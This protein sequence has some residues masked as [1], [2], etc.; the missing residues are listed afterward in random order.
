MLI[1][2]CDFLGIVIVWFGAQ[3]LSD[4]VTFLGDDKFCCCKSQDLSHPMNRA[5]YYFNNARTTWLN[6]RP[7]SKCRGNRSWETERRRRCR[8][9]PNHDGSRSRERKGERADALGISNE[10]SVRA[11]GQESFKV[12]QTISTYNEGKV[13]IADNLLQLTTLLHTRFPQLWGFLRFSIVLHLRP[14]I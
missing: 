14:L 4:T 5:M 3:C 11:N 7:R 10:A 8:R 1:G 13:A 6:Q 12:L 2:Y 9:R